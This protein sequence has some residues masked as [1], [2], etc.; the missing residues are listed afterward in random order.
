MF[1]K[2]M[3]FQTKGL[4]ELLVNFNFDFLGGQF[5]A[6]S[7]GAIKISSIFSYLTDLYQSLVC[8]DGR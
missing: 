2:L 4:R 8:I 3:T 6:E 7:L 5:I 1:L